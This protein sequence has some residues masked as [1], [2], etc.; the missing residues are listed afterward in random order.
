[1]RIS[2]ANTGPRMNVDITPKE[3]VIAKQVKAEFKIILK[4]MEKAINIVMDLRDA[5]V[6]ERP[7]K[8]ILKSKYRGRLVR[9]RSKIRNTFNVFLAHVRDTLHTMDDIS[10]PEMDRL[11]EI[12]IAEIE[13]LS[14]G[15]E[16]MLDLLKESD[17]ESFTQTL[18]GIAAQLE[19]RQKSITDVIDSQLFNHIEHD[20]LGKVKVSELQFNIKRRARVLRQLLSRG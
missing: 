6:E 18:E 5:L 15:V 1:M 19:K 8:D 14:D 10:D 17:R 12:L 13:E 2:T 7:S 9:Y 16:A 11:R 4:E 20:I 3:R